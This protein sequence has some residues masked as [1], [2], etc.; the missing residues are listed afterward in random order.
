MAKPFE[1]CE[2]VVIEIKDACENNLKRVDVQIKQGLT[3]VTGVSGSG[4]SSLVFDTIYH[5]AR[6]RYLEIFS[7]GITGLRLTPAK[8]GEVRGVGP[9]V[10]IDQNVLNNNPQ[11]VLATMS[12]LHP[13]MRILFARFG[14]RFCPVCRTPLRVSKEEDLVTTLQDLGRKEP[15]ELVVPLVEGV[16]GGHTHLCEFLSEKYGDR[17]VV[18]GTTY[19]GKFLDPNVPHSIQVVLGFSAPGHQTRDAR[20]FLESAKGLLSSRAILRT[21]STEQYFSFSNTCHCCGYWFTDLEPTLFHQKCVSC[22]GEGCQ[23]CN[24][25]G[26]HPE[27]AVVRWQSYSLPE[28]L[29]LSVKTVKDIFN[30]TPHPPSLNRLVGEVNKRLEALSGVGLDYLSLDR[31]APTLSRGESQ[32]VRLAITLVSELEDMLH[33]LDEPTIGL[34]MADVQQVTQQFRKLRGPVIFV[35]HDRFAAALA[36]HAVDIGPS[37]GPNGGE[38]M[39]AGPLAGLWDHPSATGRHY[40][41]KVCPN[42]PKK[43]K[44]TNESITIV[45]ATLR[46]LKGINVVFPKNAITVVCGVSGSGKTTLV[47]DVLVASLEEGNPVGCKMLL[48]A[49]ELK[50]VMVDQSPIGRNP[51]SNPATYTNLA[52]VVRNLF[53]SNSELTPSHFS[54]NRSEGACP[55]C[56]GLG[57]IEVK[58]R[59]LPSTWVPCEMCE[60]LRFSSE[61]LNV[62]VPLGGTTYSIADLYQLSIA[63]VA[64]LLVQ[65]SLLDFKER[66][67]AKTMLRA[68]LD[69]GL[70]YLSLGQPSPTLSGGEA[71]RVKLT[72]FLGKQRLSNHLIILDEPTTGLHPA[73]VGGLLVVLDR[74]ARNGATIV[75]VEH[76]SDLLRSADWVVDLGPGPGE[77]GGELVFNGSYEDFLHYNSSKTSRLLR[78]EVTYLQNP[79]TPSPEARKYNQK[80]L[81]V[82][83]ASLHNLQNISVT[84]PKEQVTVVTGVSGSGKSTLVSHILEGEARRRFLE[85]LSMY[86]RQSVREGEGA[87]GAEVTGL[88]VTTAVTPNKRRYDL[89]TTVGYVSE[90]SQNLAVIF[91]LLG[92]QYCPSCSKPVDRTQTSWVCSSCGRVGDV[93]TPK[94]FSPRTYEAACVKCNG[95]GF[96]SVPC[97]EKLLVDPTKPLCGGAMR[98]PGFFPKG[99]LCKPYN[100]GYYYLRALG[101][102]FG[103]DPASTPW[104]EM[105]SEAQQAFLFGSDDILEFESQGQKG[106]RSRS[107]FKNVGFYGFIRDWDIGGTYT[108]QEPCS[109][110]RGGKLRPEILSIRLGGFNFHQIHQMPLEEVLSI[111]QSVE[112]GLDS[113]TTMQVH[114][115]V[116]ERLMFLCQVGLGY[117]HLDRI[118]GTLSAGEAQRCNLARL[119]RSGLTS[120]TILLDEPTRGMHPSEVNALNQALHSLKDEG[121]TVIVVEHDL[122]IIRDADYII[123]LG[124]GAGTKGGQVVAQGS[125]DELMSTDSPTGR[126][127]ANSPRIT[128]LRRTSKPQ[129]W[130]ELVGASENNLKEVTLSI[131]VGRLVGVCGVSGSG[132]STLVVDTLGRLLAPKKQTTSVAYEPVDPGKYVRLENSPPKAIIID[133]AKK[134]I[135]NPGQFLNLEKPLVKLF[136]SSPDAEVHGLSEEH[137]SRTC[138]ACGGSG[139]VKTDMGF[140]PAIYSSCDTC[141]GSGHAPEAWEVKVKGYS[142][143]EIFT[144]TLEE[145]YSLFSEEDSISSKLKQV[146]EVGIGYLTFHQP[147]REL[148]GG[149]VQRLKITKELAKKTRSDTLYILDEPTIGLHME[150]IV[151]LTKVLQKLVDGGGTVLVV[152]HHPYLLAQCDWLV[153]L[154][155]VGGPEGGYIIFKGPPEQLA[156]ANTPTTPFVQA[157]MEGSK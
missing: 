85:S 152:E 120:L 90:L 16:R 100:F 117:I 57:A 63:E 43:R 80:E 89:R 10:A 126:W 36:D 26:L 136:A 12:G 8:V 113:T 108:T 140:L 94:H 111:I 60:G 146:L 84:I 107:T 99:Y 56:K 127:L 22:N 125:V 61:V 81:R 96:L 91:S 112:V 101:E 156:T 13:L 55:H 2:E 150:D 147:A 48:G 142:L 42:V 21:P 5:E 83:N 143:P 47:R 54:F 135:N 17:L 78:Q 34:H 116:V 28:L 51:R 25:T 24:N 50:P 86:E 65:T 102:L 31:P 128:N 18:D 95:V 6:R 46:T 58:M 103:F 32:R 64:P 76:N 69:I 153:E 129:E 123:D 75:V 87:G 29:K 145:I 7:Q 49:V 27:A 20:S 157:V 71:Q 68:L 11:S 124:P 121:N 118:F 67:K 138:S 155:P 40:S 122:E 115:K 148:S 104:V 92:I 30:S 105:S 44:L 66:K 1:W 4:K 139:Q 73:D 149:E 79:P 33:V 35:E 9:V 98:S 119:L 141:K 137:L 134:G 37:A 41:L 109:D 14:E 133:Q 97:P 3:V 110:C 19:S 132:K 144:L 59:Y 72:K 77:Q 70:G 62:R 45:E 15:V 52:T 82:K 106:R 23:K 93:A 88:G 130:I 151:Q 53:S 38:L 114:R 74:L 39:Y 154:G 131:P